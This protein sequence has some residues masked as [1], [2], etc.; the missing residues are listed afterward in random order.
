MPCR[1]NISWLFAPHNINPADVK[2]L[3]TITPT[4]EHDECEALRSHTTVTGWLSSMLGGTTLRYS[5]A[6]WLSFKAE[7][8]VT[9]GHHVNQTCAE[10]YRADDKSLV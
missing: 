6:N 5:H 4:F 1:R 10:G 7:E 8:P 9:C 3:C 2:I